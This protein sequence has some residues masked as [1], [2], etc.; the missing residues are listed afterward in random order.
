MMNEHLRR[1]VSQCRCG[2]KIERILALDGH[3]ITLTHLKFYK[4]FCRVVL[5][6]VC[7]IEI[8]ILR[9]MAVRL[10]MLDSP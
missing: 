3:N 8:D 1:D 9:A 6:D 7:C 5:H 10:D 2:V 4:S